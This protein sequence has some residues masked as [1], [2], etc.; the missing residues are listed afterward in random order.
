[1][2][3]ALADEFKQPAPAVLIVLVGLEMLG[4]LVNTGRQNGDLNLGRTGIP[5][6]KMVLA[7]DGVFL[8]FR[9]R[10][11]TRSF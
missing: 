2:P 3:A 7:Y 1:M 9:Q 5:C 8:C 10:H 11:V 4:K 6:V